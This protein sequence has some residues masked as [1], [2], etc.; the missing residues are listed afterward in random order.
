M[1]TLKER[2]HG[3]IKMF[4]MQQ[5]FKIQQGQLEYIKKL[6]NLKG[7]DHWSYISTGICALKVQE[8]WDGRFK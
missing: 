7:E 5:G 4:E 3:T 8:K 1:E 2:N 6:L